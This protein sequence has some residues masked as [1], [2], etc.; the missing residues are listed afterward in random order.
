MCHCNNDTH[1][2]LH[3]LL[4]HAK[5][6]FTE[7]LHV[8]L[9]EY[10][11][12]VVNVNSPLGMCIVQSTG[13]ILFMENNFFCENHNWIV[14][15]PIFCPAICTST[16]KAIWVSISPGTCWNG[17]K[18][19]PQHL[20]GFLLYA[21][22]ITPSTY[23]LSSFSKAPPYGWLYRVIPVNNKLRREL[24]GLSL[25]GLIF[26][27]L[28]SCPLVALPTPIHYQWKI[29]NMFLPLNCYVLSSLF[30]LLCQT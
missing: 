10:H 23:I 9:C 2:Y 20:R 4:C 8:Y 30:L 12:Y 11:I 24:Y 26:K 17:I 28:K 15:S 27:P 7:A 16:F 29:A 6:T 22:H 13:T 3:F 1:L 5:K 18:I 21:S 25:W 19:A 14:F